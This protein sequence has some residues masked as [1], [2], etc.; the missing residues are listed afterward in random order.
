MSAFF[1]SS[2][3]MTCGPHTHPAVVMLEAVANLLWLWLVVLS[4]FLLL[5]VVERKG[6]SPH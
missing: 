1:S 6:Q 5:L 3:S 2:D 4:L